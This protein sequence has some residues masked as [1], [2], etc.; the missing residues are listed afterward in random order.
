MSD[1]RPA[2]WRVVAAAVTVFSGVAALALIAMVLVICANVLMRRLGSPFLGA[3][4]IV[5]LCG[6]VALSCAIPATTAGKGH[7]A[8]EYFFHRLNRRG[9]RVVDALVHGL[10]AAGLAVAGA[11]CWRA[12]IGYR[13]SGEVTMTLQVPVFWVAWVMAASCVLAAL[14]SLYHLSHPGREMLRP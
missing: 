4:D 3:F 12:G 9:R 1:S 8:I 2:V 5:R 13:R 7:I 10:M 11:Q 14:V 6:A